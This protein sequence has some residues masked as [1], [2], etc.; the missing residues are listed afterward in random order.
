MIH[1]LW[2]KECGGI[3]VLY[4][5]FRFYSTFRSSSSCALFKHQKES[6][7]SIFVRCIIAQVLSCKKDRKVTNCQ[8]VHRYA[9]FLAI[10]I[11]RHSHLY[12]T[13]NFSNFSTNYLPFISKYIANFYK[14]KS[15]SNP[16]YHLLKVLQLFCQ[17]LWWQACLM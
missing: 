15:P 14:S 16:K 5:L 6:I 10:F 3:W 13:K 7:M 12:S 9:I 1:L 17:I 2:W 8:K 11:F 4:L